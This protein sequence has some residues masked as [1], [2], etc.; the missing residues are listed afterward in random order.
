MDQAT[1]RAASADRWI[2][3][4]PVK[5]AQLPVGVAENMSQFFGESIEAF[6]DVISAVRDVVEGDGIA[7]DELCHVEGKTPHYATTDDETY[8]FRCFYDGIA[9]AHLVGE[10]VEIRTETPTKESIEIQVSPESDIDVAPPDAVMS[11]G[12]ATDRDGPAGDG[13]TAQD[14]YG[15][16]CPYVKAFHTREDYERWAEDVAATTVG[17]PLESGVPIAAALTATAPPEVAE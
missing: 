5:T 4:R 11:F 7:I 13:P 9:L 14:V 16:V 15:S 10:Q 17:I 6:D 12:V 3:E 1:E 8:Y 2:E